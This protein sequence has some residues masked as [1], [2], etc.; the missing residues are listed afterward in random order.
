MA[1]KRSVTRSDGFTNIHGQKL[2]DITEEYREDDVVVRYQKFVEWS[3]GSDGGKLL[4]EEGDGQGLTFVIKKYEI[5]D[6][7]Y[8][9]NLQEK[10]ECD[11][12][13]STGRRVKRKREW[14]TAAGW[15]LAEYRYDADRSLSDLIYFSSHGAVLSHSTFDNGDGPFV[16]Y[17]E[18][19][20]IF[21]FGTYCDGKK[22]GTV[23]KKWNGK[24]FIQEWSD[25]KKTSSEKLGPRVWPE[26]LRDHGVQ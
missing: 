14:Y 15:K 12:T 11:W 1:L 21:E 2:Y 7:D 20:E 25:G 16:R 3:K 26:L 10:I 8:G 9:G 24:V 6:K 5:H 19:G 23:Y 18:K 22:D 17:D 4:V 13:P